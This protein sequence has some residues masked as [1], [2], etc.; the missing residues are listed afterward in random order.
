MP[1]RHREATARALEALRPQGGT[2]SL[3]P[4]EEA[5][6]LQR[7]IWE[8]LGSMWVCDTA[9]RIWASE[10]IAGHIFSAGFVVRGEP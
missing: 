7:T 10:I 8:V 1:H 3:R 4:E 9:V 2:I 6:V 5:H